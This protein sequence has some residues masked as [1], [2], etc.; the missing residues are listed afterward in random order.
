MSK[1][2]P[3]RP[4]RA[5]RIRIEPQTDRVQRHTPGSIPAKGCF[6][7]S[8]CIYRRTRLTRN[9]M[10]VS[11]C[12]GENCPCSVTCSDNSG[13]KERS[14]MRQKERTWLR[15]SR[16][17]ASSLRKNIIA[18]RRTSLRPYL[19]RSLEYC[20]R[21]GRHGV[22][23]AVNLSSTVMQRARTH[24]FA[25]PADKMNPHEVLTW[26]A[27]LSDARLTIGRCEQL[28]LRIHQNQA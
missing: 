28:I 18:H 2:C 13:R 9:G 1:C 26:P 4:A 15:A 6:S 7:N 22:R 3:F 20:R 12:R 19:R 14:A 21:C 25:A 10:C 24:R 5:T 23:K 27:P 16:T 11:L 17:S 8:A